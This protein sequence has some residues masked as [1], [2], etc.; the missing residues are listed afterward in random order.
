MERFADAVIPLLRSDSIPAMPV[1][2][3][4]LLEHDLTPEIV[5]VTASRTFS[6]ALVPT[7]PAASSAPVAAAEAACSAFTPTSRAPRIAPWTSPL[8]AVP[9]S[10]P[11]SAVLR[12]IEPDVWPMV[13]MAS[14]PVRFAP[15][16]TPITAP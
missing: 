3:E 6:A 9:K 8:A 1:G 15:W 4:R 16:S 2:L 13:S 11:T 12:M 14:E 5:P 10:P 7:L